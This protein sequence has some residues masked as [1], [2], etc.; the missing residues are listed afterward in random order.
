MSVQVGNCKKFA[1]FLSIFDWFAAASSVLNL[2]QRWNDFEL[3]MI[4]CS[5]VHQILTYTYRC[6]SLI[7]REL[8]AAQPRLGRCRRWSRL[9]WISRELSRTPPLCSTSFVEALSEM[10]Q[11]SRRASHDELKHKNRW[12][13]GCT[14]RDNMEATLAECLTWSL[15]KIKIT[16]IM[17][18]VT[19]RRKSHLIFN[20]MEYFASSS[21]H[22][23][24]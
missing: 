12:S 13:V 8:E 18:W 15:A 9:S 16:L 10:T 11:S 22:F 3:W 1:T 7:R 6:C 23:D 21:E 5:W 17:R 2:L 14:R 19:Q 20:W 24:E 4:E